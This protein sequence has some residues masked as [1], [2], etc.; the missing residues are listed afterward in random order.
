MTFQATQATFLKEIEPPQKNLLLR[1]SS[2]DITITTRNDG[3]SDDT[4]SN[5][6]WFVAINSYS[7]NLLWLK[8]VKNL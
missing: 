7:D 6:F 4:Y 5:D 2:L 3:Y 1:L 8:Y